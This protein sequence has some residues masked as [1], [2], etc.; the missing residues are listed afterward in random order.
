MPTP[1]RHGKRGIKFAQDAS[2]PGIPPIS[3]GNI[4]PRDDVVAVFDDRESADRALQALIEVGIP[5][6]DV[7]V[8]DAESVLA[9]DRE[10]RQHRGPLARL[11]SWLST[12]FSD[13][14][15]DYASYIHEAER[16]HHLVIVHAQDADV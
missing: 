7:D 10:V 16:G 4:Y 1:H 3:F 5:Q 8:I 12:A 11:E 15:A 9:T 6:D 2:Q 13:D 14:A